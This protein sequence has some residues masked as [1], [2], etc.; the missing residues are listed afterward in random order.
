MAPVRLMVWLCFKSYS[1]LVRAFFDWT[2]MRFFS[3]VFKNSRLQPVQYLDPPT[4]QHKRFSGLSSLIDKSH[5]LDSSPVPRP[6]INLQL[7]NPSCFES[8]VV[9]STFTTLC[10]CQW[11]V[12]GSDDHWT[13]RFAKSCICFPLS[14]R[15]IFRA[16]FL[17]LR[18]RNWAFSQLLLGL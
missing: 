7:S 16:R 5:Y 4:Q 10:V 6:R 17:R 13:F 3:D 18:Y 11:T 2:M 1:W 9:P 14:C 15:C 8:W 12:T